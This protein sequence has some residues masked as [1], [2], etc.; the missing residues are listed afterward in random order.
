MGKWNYRRLSLIIVIALMVFG[1][2]I[3]QTEGTKES[4]SFPN[5]LVTLD[6][7][8]TSLENSAISA[9][10]TFLSD[11]GNPTGRTNF[12][13]KEILIDE[14]F[15]G[16]LPLVILDTGGQKPGRNSIYDSEKGYY[17][18][19]DTDPYA[20]GKIWIIDNSGRENQIGRAHV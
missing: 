2:A 1:G 20:Y 12:R 6:E 9:D 16:N 19:L 3:M 18:P 17:V 7:Q 15:T 8:S 4:L 11:Y 5:P 14:N 10:E 13:D